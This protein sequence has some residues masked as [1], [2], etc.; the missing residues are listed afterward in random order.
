MLA[1]ELIT[2][3]DDSANLLIMTQEG[4]VVF[5][6]KANRFENIYKDL[7]IENILTINDTLKI[8]VSY[9]N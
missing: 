9:D 1:Q 5:A 3:I 7:Y 8:V 6:D 2:Y 4:K